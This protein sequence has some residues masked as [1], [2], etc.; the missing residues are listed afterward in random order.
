[1]DARMKAM[2]GAAVAAF[3]VF[4]LGVTYVY[5][6]LRESNP[7]SGEGMFAA[8]IMLAIAVVVFTL[9]FDWA[10]RATGSAIKA[11]MTM[12]LAQVALVDVYYPMQGERSWAAAAASAAL[13]IVGWF[14]IGTVYAKL[15]AGGGGGGGGGAAEGMGAGS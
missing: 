15:S 12:A 14:V 3:I 1:M 10:A 2:L 4:Y 7:G 6:P 13:L 11:A 9:I 8:P 5:G